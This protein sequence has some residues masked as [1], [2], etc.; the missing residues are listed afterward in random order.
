MRIEFLPLRAGRTQRRGGGDR[1]VCLGE[2]FDLADQAESLR[3]PL[4]RA[5]RM[6]VVDDLGQQRARAFAH[7]LLYLSI[8]C[9]RVENIRIFD[10]FEC[11]DGHVARRVTCGDA[12]QQG[13]VGDPADGVEADRRIVTPARDFCQSCLLPNLRKRRTANLRMRCLCGDC[14]AVARSVQQRERR[15]ALVHGS[16]GDGACH[17]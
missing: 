3:V 5:Q 9:Q 1:I 12:P 6:G 8:L 14:G 11:R 10:P 13:R 15:E 2:P 16:R 7:E 17:E 4:G